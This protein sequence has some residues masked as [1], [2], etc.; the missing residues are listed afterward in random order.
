MS[1]PV[2]T[3]PTVASGPYAMASLYVGDLHSAVTEAQLFEKFSQAGPV[4]SIRVCRDAVTRRS[5]GYA[6]V[7]FQQPEHAK[8]ALDTMN[9]D[10]MNGRSMRIMWSNRDPSARRS[11][12]GNIFIKNLDKSIDHKALHDTF[13]LFGNILSCKV[14]TDDNGESKGYGFVHFEEEDAAARAIEKVNGMLLAE[15]MVFVG[16]FK[17]RSARMRELGESP[18]AFNNVFVKNFGSNLDNEG[19]QKLFEKFGPIESCV[20]MLDAEDKSKG[21]GFVSFEKSDDALK[22][23]EGL[24]GTIIDG[25]E[26]EQKLTVCRAQKRS[27]RAAEL[28]HRY[29]QFKIDTMQR[30][31]GVNLYV[32]NLDD[33]VDDEGLNKLFAA[34]GKITSAKVMKDEADRSKGFGFVCFEKPD[35]ATKAQAEMNG[36]IMTSKPLYVA[37]AQRK[38]DR[39]A[40][41]ASQYMQRLASARTTQGVAIPTGQ[42]FAPAAGGYFVNPMQNPY[43]A[44]APMPMAA[45]AVRRWGGQQPQG[46]QQQYNMMGGRQ[47]FRH[48]GAGGMPPRRQQ[49]GMPPRQQKP[50]QQAGAGGGQHV[51]QQQTTLTAQMLAQATPQEQKQMLGESIYEK[52]TQQYGTQSDV[53][54]LT[55]MMLEIDNSELLMLLNDP[56]LFRQRVQEAANVLSSAG[57]RN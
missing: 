49:G 4:L 41:L 14:A 39:R 56:E 36:K 24:D 3:L 28:K 47:N 6:Y 22:A 16:K 37:M 21:F 30:Y 57:Q 7:N 45:T 13:S 17:P 48:G 26:A 9:F 38:E 50:Y 34:Y 11:G 33:S 35:E 32:K 31:Q 2:T 12:A 1:V 43:M 40:H 44:T 42:M 20:V 5:L 29:E 54:K 55:G 46:G 23:V 27:E 19:L 51:D 8:V 18:H 53:G 52:I 15:K 10:P 25:G